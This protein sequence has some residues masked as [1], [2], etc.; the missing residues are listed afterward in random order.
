MPQR[1][2]CSAALSAHHGS[3]LNFDYCLYLSEILTSNKPHFQFSERHCQ[4]CRVTPYTARWCVRQGQQEIFA[5]LR[6]VSFSSDGNLHRLKQDGFPMRRHPRPTTQN[7]YCGYQKRPFL[8][9][10]RLSVT[11]GRH[12]DGTKHRENQKLDAALASSTTHAHRRYN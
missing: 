7:D 4:V 6:Q 11:P 1:V 2:R 9:V 10:R 3:W 5:A 8:H 12:P